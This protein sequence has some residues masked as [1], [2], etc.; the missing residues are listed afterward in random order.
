MEPRLGAADARTLSV[1]GAEGGVQQPRAHISSLGL[2]T[3]HRA[4]TVSPAPTRTLA[5]GLPTV[6][7]LDEADLEA[8]VDSV[9]V[10]EADVRATSP[11]VT[12]FPRQRRRDV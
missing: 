4:E 12:L 9:T 8:T 5:F 7:P 3:E 6:H 1:L 11:M 10:A 2:G